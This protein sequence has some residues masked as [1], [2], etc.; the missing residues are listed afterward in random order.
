[1]N[2]KL[3]AYVSYTNINKS[4][5]KLQCVVEL[6]ENKSERFYDLQAEVNDVISKD[7][8][9]EVKLHF[10]SKVYINLLFDNNKY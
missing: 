5:N 10:K 1:M 8:I 6:T 2:Q 7:A 3:I 4:K 9:G